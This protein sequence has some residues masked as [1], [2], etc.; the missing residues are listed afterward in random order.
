MSKRIFFGKDAREKLKSG[1]DKIS[2]A[3]KATLGY[4]GRN[5][6][7]SNPRVMSF[8][9][10]DGVTVANEVMLEDPI[11]NAGALIIKGVARK[12]LNECG[13]GTTTATIFA[14][15]LITRGLALVDN[16]ANPVE[17]KKGIDKATA[18][19]VAFIKAASKPVDNFEMIKSV[20]TIAAN[21]DEFMGN[22]IAEAYHKIGKEGIIDIEE[23]G[24]AETKMELVAG[25]QVDIG[26]MH[27]IFINN[28]VK[29]ITELRD[30]RIIIYNGV[31]SSGKEMAEALNDVVIDG[32]SCL[33]IVEDINGEA[34]QIIAE[35]KSRGFPFCVIKC[36]AYGELREEILEDIA[37]VTRAIVRSKNKADKF[38]N[39]KRQHMGHADKV[40]VKR[41]DTIIIG[42]N[43]D[44]TAVANR[45][46]EIRERIKLS[47]S[48]AEKSEQ[49]KRLAKILGGVA[50][51]KIGGVSDI[52]IR[53]KRDRADDAIRATKA[54]ME[55]GVVPGAGTI[56]IRAIHNVNLVRS[57]SPDERKGIDL[58]KVVLEAPLNQILINAAK[59]S[60]QFIAR[61]FDAAEN[62]GYDGKLE[63][64]T[65]L[66]VTGVIDP[67]KVCRFAIENAASVAGVVIT[68]EVLMV[69]VE[70]KVAK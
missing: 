63:T 20:S 35:N 24:N 7:I 5:V 36:P 49:E 4:N 10:K 42:G 62:F 34:M 44:E 16:G 33:L 56:F 41:N 40:I 64:V 6:I 47:E 17:I 53:E 12:M 51:I 32:K 38:G 69:E 3:V 58:V 70:D 30:V 28:Q 60:S 61:V 31:V 22:L 15:E 18:E 57:D 27:P 54:A 26:I 25:M 14:Q 66:T 52:E 23:S 65:D 46:E 55:E 37:T 21:N 8:A 59:D 50:S 1:V 68:S 43:G 39:T 45:V 11:E 13:D 48:A 19:V 67:A 2:N 29:M 9:T